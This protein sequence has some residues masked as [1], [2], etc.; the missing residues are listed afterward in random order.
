MKKFYLCLAVALLGLGTAMHWPTSHAS[1]DEPSAAVDQKQDLVDKLELISRIEG[2]EKRLAALEDRDSLIRQADNREPSSVPQ[3]ERF[4]P[5]PSATESGLPNFDDASD[6]TD[7]DSDDLQQ[8][9]GQKW[10]FRL[11]IDR[12]SQRPSLKAPN[13]VRDNSPAKSKGRS[14]TA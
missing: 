5:S 9:N 3:P 1:D 7:A 13:Q 11:L 8:T 14:P 2:L 12:K 4:S 6:A 10:S